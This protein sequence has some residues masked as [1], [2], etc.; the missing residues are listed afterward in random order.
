MD[1]R[2]LER[3]GQETARETVKIMSKR[4]GHDGTITL[5]MYLKKKV[6]CTGTHGQFDYP[7]TF[8][9]IL[10]RIQIQSACAVRGGGAAPS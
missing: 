7:C 10:I 6:A 9:K 2:I 5:T 4:Q 1:K 8:I 3:V